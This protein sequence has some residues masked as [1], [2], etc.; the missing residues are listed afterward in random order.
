MPAILNDPT[1]FAAKLMD[2]AMRASLGIGTL[3]GESRSISRE[4]RHYKAR[5]GLDAEDVQ[6][7]VKVLDDRPRKQPNSG[8]G[9]RDE[10]ADL[11]R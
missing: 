10:E 6:N 5:Y 9:L 7:A 2:G 4:E 1:G 3:D 11:L 8:L